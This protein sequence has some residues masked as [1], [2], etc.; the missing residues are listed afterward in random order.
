LRR[1]D[2]PHEQSGSDTRL[3]FF[4]LGDVDLGFGVAPKCAHHQPRL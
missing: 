4:G 2:R 3:D 1:F